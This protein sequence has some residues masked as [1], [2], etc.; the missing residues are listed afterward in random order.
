[1]IVPTY[2]AEARRQERTRERQVTV[3]RFGW[4]D[5][6]P[7][8]AQAM[9]EARVDEAFERAKQDRNWPRYERRVAYNG[10]EGVPIREEVLARYGDAVITRNGYGARCLNTPDV[11]FA[12]V[13]FSDGAPGQ[14]YKACALPMALGAIALGSQIG[15]IVLTIVLILI[16]LILAIFV[17]NFAWR[18]WVQLRGG[19]EAL[20]LRRLHK[21]LDAHREWNVRVYRTPAGLRLLATHAPQAP[22]DSATQEFFRALGVDPIYAQM[23]RNQNCFRARLTGKPWRIGVAEH[24]RPRRRTWPIPPERLAERQAWVA[25]YEHQAQNFA[26]CRYVDSFG[27]GFIHDRV[28]ATVERHDEE[29]RALGTELALA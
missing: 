26:A 14:L 27:S 1:M 2:W 6:S 3:R 25:N 15:S 5:D 13:D 17:A 7:E 22:R 4:S 28:R 19:H 24:I 12:D 9:A 8:A 18:T 11:L 21:Y 16:A 23:C 10:S 20:A 29:C